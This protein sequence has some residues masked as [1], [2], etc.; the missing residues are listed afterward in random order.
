MHVTL[1]ISYNYMNI[2]LNQRHVFNTLHFGSFKIFFN[3]S[4]LNR[5]RLKLDMHRTFF[6]TSKVTMKNQLTRF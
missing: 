4:K 3:G 2:I 5:E 1:I 6:V